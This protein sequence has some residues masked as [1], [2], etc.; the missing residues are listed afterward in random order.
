MCR[1][2]TVHCSSGSYVLALSNKFSSIKITFQSVEHY[3]FFSSSS[4]V[5]FSFRIKMF[6]KSFCVCVWYECVVNNVDRLSERV[7][8]GNENDLHVVEIS[9]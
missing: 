2:S 8:A 4:S 3:N 5:V 7:P 9:T 1:Q 6:M